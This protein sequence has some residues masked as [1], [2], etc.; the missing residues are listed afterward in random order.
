MLQDIKDGNQADA[1]IKKYGLA[2]TRVRA[3]AFHPD[4]IPHVDPCT[5]APQDLLHLFP[6]GIVRHEGAWL[7]WVLLKKGLSLEAANS[8]IRAYR[9]WPSD[10]RIPSLHPSLK[11]GEAGGPK[12]SRVLRMTGAQV[13]HFTLHS[14]EV[15]GPLL[16]PEMIAH[17]AWAS[18]CKLVELFV[19][20][21][22]TILLTTTRCRLW[23]P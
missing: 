15:L 10:V 6:D 5:I 23:T 7:M 14:I 13:M 3:F 4:Y 22:S 18:W 19:L 2:P 21:P 17:P 8:A 1:L 11:E 16:T 9:D 12:S 20:W